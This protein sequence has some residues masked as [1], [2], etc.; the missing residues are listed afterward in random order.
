MINVQ[1]SNKDCKYYVVGFRCRAY[2]I[3]IDV[4]GVCYDA[5]P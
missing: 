5:K 4:N 1:C 2:N 3:V